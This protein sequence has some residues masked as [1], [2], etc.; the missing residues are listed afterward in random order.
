MKLNNY[1]LEQTEVVGNEKYES[2]SS[3]CKRL[4]AM[5]FRN[6]TTSVGVIGRKEAVSVRLR[7][8][9]QEIPEN[10]PLLHL[11]CENGTISHR[12]DAFFFENGRAGGILLCVIARNILS[13][14][15][16]LRFPCSEK[17]SATGSRKKKK[18]LTSKGDMVIIHAGRCVVRNFEN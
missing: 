3:G 4:S 17:I 13:S 12:L 15:N 1:V 2:G 6:G 9:P 11:C 5:T 18:F 14:G 16:I 10:Y 8:Q 7:E